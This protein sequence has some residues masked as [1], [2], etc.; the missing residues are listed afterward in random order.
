MLIAYIDNENSNERNEIMN[1]IK[2]IKSIA[3]TIIMVIIVLAILTHF[4][5]IAER[6]Y[7]QANRNAAIATLNG[8]EAEFAAQQVVKSGGEV[9]NG[10]FYL[11]IFGVL[12]F[13]GVRIYRKVNIMRKDGIKDNHE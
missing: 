8:G 12:M 7:S 1:C 4:H 13:S 5:S 2:G 9:I 10:S 6:I 11:A 3:P